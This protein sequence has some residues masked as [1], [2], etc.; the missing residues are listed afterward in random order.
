[1][2]TTSPSGRPYGFPSLST[3]ELKQSPSGVGVTSERMASATD[4][5]STDSTRGFRVVL[6]P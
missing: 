5:A 4:T 6:E 1:M 2:D 3:P